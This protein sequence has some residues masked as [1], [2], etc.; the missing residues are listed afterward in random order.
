[1]T[2]HSTFTNV[3]FSFAGN[4][5][6]MITNTLDNLA[7]AEWQP[8]VHF[9]TPVSMRVD[10]L[11]MTFETD[12][13]STIT[14]DFGTVSFSTT[15]DPEPDYFA[16]PALF[17][18]L[19]YVAGVNELNTV[20]VSGTFTYLYGSP[21]PIDG[22]STFT[23]GIRYNSTG[24]DTSNLLDLGGLNDPSG[25]GSD[26]STYDGVNYTC[27]IGSKSKVVRYGPQKI[28]FHREYPL[29]TAKCV[30]SLDAPQ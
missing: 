11:Q 26:A 2:T 27:T 5:A 10:N 1:M 3:P 28:K 19:S 20:T 7:T 15:G 24:N 22:V 12:D 25:T 23:A 16:S 6:G 14:Y 4:T 21:S 8:I 18:D 13:A 9:N 30:S 29:T 17:P